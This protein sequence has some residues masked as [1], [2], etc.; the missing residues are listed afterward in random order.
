MPLENIDEEGLPR[1]PDLQL[2]QWRFL[3]TTEG[4]QI[5][6]ETIW[7]Q[8]LAAIKEKGLISQLY[9]YYYCYI[10][11]FRYGSILFLSVSRTSVSN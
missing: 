3:L 2:A 4:D 9:I 5:D 7:T 6:R 1:N 8:L 10:P 11:T